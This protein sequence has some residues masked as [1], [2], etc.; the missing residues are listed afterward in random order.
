VQLHAATLRKRIRMANVAMIDH[1]ADASLRSRTTTWRGLSARCPQAL[2][3]TTS[4][5]GFRCVRRS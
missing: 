2:D 3:T 4:H 1:K 5:I